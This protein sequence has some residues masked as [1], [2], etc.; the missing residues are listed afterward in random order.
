MQAIVVDSEKTLRQ[1][2]EDNRYDVII[3][4]KEIRVLD[5]FTAY[6]KSTLKNI[7]QLFYDEVMW[8]PGDAITHE[9][10]YI[11]FYAVQPRAQVM[12]WLCKTIAAQLAERAQPQKTSEELPRMPI[13][14]PLHIRQA[15]Q[16]L[17]GQKFE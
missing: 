2:L 7:L 4:E 17:E 6:I 9:N 13:A 12:P 3:Y 1:A 14:I 5:A 16:I 10:G 15:I 8:I 11:T